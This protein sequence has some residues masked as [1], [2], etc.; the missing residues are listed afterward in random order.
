MSDLFFYIELTKTLESVEPW[1]LSNEM[2]ILFINNILAILGRLNNV[3]EK[4]ISD[5]IDKEVFER[6][7]CLL[8]RISKITDE[9][10]LVLIPKLLTIFHELSES[11]SEKLEDLFKNIFESGLTEAVRQEER[12]IIFGMF[13]EKCKSRTGIT[14]SKESSKSMDLW[15]KL[16]ICTGVFIGRN[17]LEIDFEDIDGL[18]KM[19][20]EY[21]RNMCL[22]IPNS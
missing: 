20:D 4:K 21:W 13:C 8:K 12:Q 6:I 15:S 10:K 5:K 14:V 17:E 16:N 1:K 9:K 18:L 19:V 2:L 7:K 11:K 22:K 3:H